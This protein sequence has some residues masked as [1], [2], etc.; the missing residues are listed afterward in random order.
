MTFSIK[1]TGLFALVLIILAPYPALSMTPVSDE[2]LEE[3]TAGEGVSIIFSNIQTSLDF[4][5]ISVHDTDGT[6]SAGAGYGLIP[7]FQGNLQINRLDDVGY[8]KDI[9]GDLGYDPK[10]VR[11][12]NHG[13]RI[14]EY[15]EY[16]RD[17]SLSAAENDYAYHDY[18]SIDNGTDMQVLTID[19][20]NSASS[21]GWLPNGGL[22]IGLPTV[23]VAITGVPTFDFMVNNIISGEL[24]DGPDL[25]GSFAMANNYLELL[26]GDIGITPRTG[27]GLDLYF[28][29]VKVYW[30]T[31]I[32]N[33]IGATGSVS[34]NTQGADGS[35]SIQ[36]NN[37]LLHGDTEEDPTDTN[38]IDSDT[39]TGEYGP[40]EI[41]GLMSINMETNGVRSYLQA[42]L[43]N[44]TDNMNLTLGQMKYQGVDFGYWGLKDIIITNNSYI[45]IGGRNGGGTAAG[46]DFEFSAGLSIG[47]L[48]YDYGGGAANFTGISLCN[49]INST[50]S[51]TTNWNP[52][53]L[54][55]MGNFDT[56]YPIQINA[57]SVSSTSHQI[58]ISVPSNWTNP[59]IN[60]SISV[61][62]FNI[63]GSIDF[64]AIIVEGIQVHEL[65]IT[66][67]GS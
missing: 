24:A 56:G 51:T 32:F 25:F 41:S 23:Q 26:G 50:S 61:E 29:N 28:N 3:I 53:G 58:E 2:V 18:T 11:H 35:N 44:W 37:L 34:N 30:N 10:C 54:F 15:G 62:N 45:R 65:T 39:H 14:G 27:Q 49:T 64:G 9:S 17:N 47:S 38:W 1:K 48:V 67:N 46:I 60:G 43:S 13:N 12:G 16:E 42:K 22:V 66:L 40:Y 7:V 36:L 57:G 31:E 6:S 52:T 59:P 5:P 63:G 33:I 20:Y 55:Q 21:P 8:R 19:T 4:Q